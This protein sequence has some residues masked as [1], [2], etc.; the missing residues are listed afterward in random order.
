MLGQI[1]QAFAERQASEERLRRFLAD[2]SHE[3]RTPLSSIRG[4]AELFR[5]GAARQPGQL[6]RAM[7]RIEDEAAQMGI[8]VNDLLTLARL[9]EVT[10]RTWELVDV[11]ALADEACDDARTDDGERTVDFT[12][13]GTTTVLGDR[14][15][16]RRVLSNLLGNAVMHTLPGTPIEVKVHG[17]HGL[18]TLAVRDYGP[19]LAPGS[20]TLVFERFWQQRPATDGDGDSGTGLG[21]A[22]VAAIAKAHGCSVAAANAAGGGAEFTVALPAVGDTPIQPDP[23]AKPGGPRPR[24]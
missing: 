18:V 10:E 1:E 22:I 13:H 15:Q 16:L 24:S 2:A 6:E 17:D 12:C 5:T 20:E 21:L 9:D 3:L 19:G 14:D 7:R 11:A 4:Y 23:D 8:L